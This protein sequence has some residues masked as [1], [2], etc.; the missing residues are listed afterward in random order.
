MDTATN[1]L[2]VG[3]MCVLTFGLLL[4]VPMA[5]ARSKAAR[6]PRYLFAAHLAAI[7]QGG[8]LLALTI[9]IGFSSLSPGVEMAGASLLVGGVALFDL[10]LA[11]NWLQGVQDAFAEE[12]LGN[13]I[14][15]VGTPLVLIGNGI[16]LYGVVAAL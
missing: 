14:S 1:V 3:G 15:G 13:K 6:A 11:L 5:G 7:I 9:A 16:I 12:S 8:M 4:G 2:I 10:G